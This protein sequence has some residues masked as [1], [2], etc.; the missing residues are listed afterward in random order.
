MPT[1]TMSAAL[2]KVREPQQAA[3]VIGM[4]AC[5]VEGSNEAMADAALARLRDEHRQEIERAIDNVKRTA[6][7]R[8]FRREFYRVAARR[9]WSPRRRAAF[10]HARQAGCASECRRWSK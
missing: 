2:R 8:W 4:D 5:R 7:D 10:G 9:K 1:L 3:E 6:L